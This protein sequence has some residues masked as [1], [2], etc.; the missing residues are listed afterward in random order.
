MLISSIDKKSLADFEPLKH[1]QDGIRYGLA[2]GRLDQEYVS[3]GSP[4]HSYPHVWA[5]TTLGNDIVTQRW[6]VP[7]LEYYGGWYHE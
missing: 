2:R 6:Y 5:S 1:Q 7:S 4:L 3:C